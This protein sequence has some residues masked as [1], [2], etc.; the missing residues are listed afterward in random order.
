M[1]NELSKGL[2]IVLLI[3]FALGI[4]LGIIFL[5]IPEIY[6]SLVGFPMIDSGSL[7][8]IGAA[9]L[10]LGS[11]SF[12]AFRTN[13]W[14]KTKLFIIM[15]FIWLGGAIVAML[16]WLIELGS[17]GVAGWWIFGMFLGF[18]A[19]FGYSYYLQER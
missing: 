1:P 9:S 4:I 14:E 11:S 7:R 6:C 8:I 19:A 5:F 13:D 2:K 10:A 18:L 3:H 16:W 17:S 15:E 12:L